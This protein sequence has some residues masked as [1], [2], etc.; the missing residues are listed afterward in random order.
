MGAAARAISRP[1]PDRKAIAAQP[2]P[3]VNRYARFAPSRL[4]QDWKR[5]HARCNRANSLCRL[6]QHVV[7]RRPRRPSV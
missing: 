1:T 4:D 2:T 5:C 7:K 3:W 6:F